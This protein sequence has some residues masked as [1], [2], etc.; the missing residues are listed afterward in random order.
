MH[1]DTWRLRRGS[2]GV[3]GDTSECTVTPQSVWWHLGVHT[4]HRHCQDQTFALPKASWSSIF[5]REVGD[6]LG[7]AD[8]APS[9]QGCAGCV[10]AALGFSLPL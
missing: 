7:P 4:R 10:A 8:A 3:H 2:L 9:S 5:P 1:C 6:A